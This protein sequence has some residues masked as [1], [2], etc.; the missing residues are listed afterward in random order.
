MCVL[1]EDAH[2]YISGPNCT[3]SKVHKEHLK[4]GPESNWLSSSKNEEQDNMPQ[5]EFDGEGSLKFPLTAP[6]RK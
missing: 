4:S 6:S 3:Y 1:S 2:Q 5:V